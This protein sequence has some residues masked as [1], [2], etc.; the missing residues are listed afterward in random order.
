M[1]RDSN[2]GAQIAQQLIAVFLKLPLAAK[3]G[4][5]VLVLIVGGVMYAFNRHEG[6]P[7]RPGEENQSESNS[8]ESSEPGDQANVPPPA[9]A[10]PPGSKSVVFCVWNMENLFDDK[11]D[12]R[13]RP[14]GEFDDWFARDAETRKLKYQHLTEALLK[15]NGGIGPDIIV[16]NEA[17]SL[18]S[19]ELLQESLN[20]N[21]PAGAVRYEHIAMKEL[22]NAGRH[23][24]PCVISRFTL[25][26]VKILGH[27]ER[28]LEV[29]VTINGHDLFLVAS[30]WT[31]QLSD[32]GSRKQGGRNGYATV[33]AEVYHEAILADPKIDFL[34]CGDFND[35]PQSESVHRTLHMISDYRQVTADAKPP[36]LFGLLAGKSPNDFGTIYY[37][38]PLIYDHIGF[39]PGMFD[40]QGWGYDPASVRVPTDGLIEPGTKGRHPW[41]FGS[42]KDTHSRGYS[43]HFP[44][45]V[46]LKVAP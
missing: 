27:R 10:F 35:T 26:H 12:H 5:I 15:M 19:A 2:A 42:P 43:D 7:Q 36:K 11:E 1:A 34:V 16:G 6:P 4:V 28:I 8:S 3:V 46:T 9:A 22:G 20:A 37:K 14:D 39:S 31:S 29:H 44:V 23:I 30:H 40:N 45:V 18:R 25:D 33:I 38:K 24:A 17:E 21:L 32:D 41:R 13:P